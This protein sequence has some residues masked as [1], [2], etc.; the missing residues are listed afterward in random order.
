MGTTCHPLP[1]SCHAWALRF[2]L[3]RPLPLHAWTRNHC[4]R[5]RGYC[6]VGIGRGVRQPARTD[7][8]DCQ[9]HLWR[10]LTSFAR[11]LHLDKYAILAPEPVSLP[12]RERYWSSV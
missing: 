5:G 8:I 12:L 3:A 4:W 1:A 2:C 6:L 7:W 11:L 9:R 10:L